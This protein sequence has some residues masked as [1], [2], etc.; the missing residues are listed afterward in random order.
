MVGPARRQQAR[1]DVSGIHEMRGGQQV[2]KR[3][4]LP[5]LRFHHRDDGI[6]PL[7]PLSSANLQEI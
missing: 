7:S 5:L 2:P 6:S 1:I 4:A 3:L